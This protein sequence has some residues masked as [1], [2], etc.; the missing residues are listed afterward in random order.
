[1]VQNSYQRNYW[2]IRIGQNFTIQSF[3]PMWSH[4][5]TDPI[6]QITVCQCFLCTM[7]H[8]WSAN[9]G[10]LMVTMV[11]SYTCVGG[12]EAEPVMLGYT[13][14]MVLPKMVRYKLIRPPQL[15]W[16]SWSSRWLSICLC[17]CQVFS[18][19]YEVY[20]SL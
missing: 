3:P 15:M 8:N 4:D 20:E 14:N 18:F 6:D 2:W 12:I 17:C 9:S 5:M 19:Y 11:Y 7:Q 10:M 16:C 13:F 1:M